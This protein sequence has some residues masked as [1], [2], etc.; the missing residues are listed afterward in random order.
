MSETCGRI[1]LVAF[2]LDGT[3]YVGDQSIPGGR[4]LIAALR[5]HYQVAFFTNNSSKADVEI[6]DKLER[7]GYSCCLEEVYTSS[8]M[9][10]RYLR[11]SGLDNL[12][13]IGSG[14]FRRTLQGQG[15]SLVD[16]VTAANLVV[17]LDPQFHYDK[18]AVA[19][20]VLRHGGRFI[21]CNEDPSYPVGT[22]THLPGCGAMVGA[23][24]VCAGRRPDFIVGKPNTYIM[25]VMAQTYHVTPDEIVVV[26][27]TY[28]SDIRM[29]L[30]FNCRAILFGT[31]NGVGDDGVRA[32]ESHD[33]ILHYLREDR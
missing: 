20:T 4:E 15:L 26:G 23:I 5:P 7:L 2:D 19:L 14:G 31:R 25:S 22:D 16:D 8:A 3:L 33:Q 13:V 29:A 12:Y 30:N 32:M 24:A 28:E 21:A 6:R 27:D 11:E 17:G 18:I 1:R 9:A 10:A